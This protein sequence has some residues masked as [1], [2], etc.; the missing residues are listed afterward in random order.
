MEPLTQEEKIEC[1]RIALAICG[2]GFP[3]KDL[4]LFARVYDEMLE[5]SGEV[6]LREVVKIHRS[7]EEKHKAVKVEEP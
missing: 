3:K 7:I 2:Y 6:D 5:K 4:E 1:F